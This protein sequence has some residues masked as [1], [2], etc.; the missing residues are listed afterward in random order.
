MP[1]SPSSSWAAPFYDVQEALTG[2][3]SAEPHPSHA[4]QVRGL[5][6]QFPQASTLL[7][8]GAGGG[9]FAVTAAQAGLTV[10]AL[11]L[12]ASAAGHA[13][14]LARQRGVPLEVV[15]ESFYTADLTGPFDLIVYWDG[16]GIGTDDEQRQLLRRVAGWL[17]PGGHAVLD[18]YTP[19][20]WARHAGFTRRTETCTQV[21]GFD[22][23]GC[24]MTDTYTGQDGVEHTQ[25]LRCYSP[26]DLSL[27]LTGTGLHLAAAEPGGQFDPAA[28]QWHPQA[29]WHRCM[30]FQAVL[31][32]AD[33][34]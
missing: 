29:E 22:A 2:Y 17:A 31:T 33:R 12:R 20:Y 16:F 5:R 19:W 15:Q 32:H 27:L 7:E 34:G 28:G 4:G 30:T 23:P 13:R 18:V 1:H 8:L 26:Q 25:S 3:Y 14:Q 6:A 10:T 11:E 9:Q 21:Y 24:R